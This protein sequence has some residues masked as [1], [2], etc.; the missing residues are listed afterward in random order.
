FSFTP[1][2]TA[3]NN[4]ASD[5]LIQVEKNGVAALYVTPNG[6]ANNEGNM[7][8]NLRRYV[9]RDGGRTWTKAC[10]IAADGIAY[11][12]VTLVH[13]A[14]PDGAIVFC[15]RDDNTIYLWGRRGFVGG[16][17]VNPRPE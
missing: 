3:C 2:A 14:H 7:G 11:G 5:A 10:E 6:R 1:V 16:N 13:H 12:A 8:G 9:T 17:A 15:N 4:W